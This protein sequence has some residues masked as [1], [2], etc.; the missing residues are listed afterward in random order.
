MSRGH[1]NA[2]PATG[3]LPNIQRDA[4]VIFMDSRLAVCLAIISYSTG[5]FA[6]RGA[7]YAP[8]HR[9]DRG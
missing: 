7:A 1:R 6:S 9:P 2:T 3:D 5:Q 8:S 4:I